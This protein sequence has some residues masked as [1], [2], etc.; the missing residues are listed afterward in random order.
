MEWFGS[1]T[2]KM[3]VAYGK[4]DPEINPPPFSNW[5]KAF[6]V[7][8]IDLFQYYSWKPKTAEYFR[9]WIQRKGIRIIPRVGVRTKRSPEEYQD[10]VNLWSDVYGAETAYFLVYS[11]RQEWTS[12][13]TLKELQSLPKNQKYFF[14]WGKLDSVRGVDF[15][16]QLNLFRGWVIDPEWHHGFLSSLSDTPLHFK[17]HGWSEERWVR[18]YGVSQVSRML[19]VVKKREGAILTLAYSGKVAEAPLFGEG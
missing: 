10:A 14:E 11:G 4:F 1:K 2:T 8:E 17:L 6:N 16:K 13:Q 7:I 19:R 3:Q 5:S 18:R 12:I 15:I 9:A